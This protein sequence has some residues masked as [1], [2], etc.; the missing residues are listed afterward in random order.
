MLIQGRLTEILRTMVIEANNYRESI[1][2]SR[3]HVI[4]SLRVWTIWSIHKGRNNFFPLGSYIPTRQ[5]NH[6]A[7]TILALYKVL[8]MEL[9]DVN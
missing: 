2:A 8:S 4:V 1:A 9:N 3:L 7:P 6:M 5:V